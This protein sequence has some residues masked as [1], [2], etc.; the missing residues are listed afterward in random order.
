M[1]RRFLSLLAIGLVVLIAVGAGVALGVHWAGVTNSMAVT[2]DGDPVQGSM[3]AAGIGAAVAVAAVV[4][5]V[6]VVVALASVAV[7]VPIAIIGAICV[8]VLAAIVGLS[9][10][11]IPVALIVGVCMLISR[12]SS[13]R[14]MPST[15]LAPER[16]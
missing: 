6:I 14:S 13:R 2:I 3:V 1:M 7:I 16:Q 10:L 15:P 8:A 11:L 9:P 12:R 4:G 5:C